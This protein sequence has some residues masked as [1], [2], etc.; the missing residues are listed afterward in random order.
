V[1]TSGPWVEVHGPI[2]TRAI[3][4][5]RLKFTDICRKA[6]DCSRIVHVRLQEILRALC[7]E[8]RVD[9]IALEM[10]PEHVHLDAGWASFLA[11][12]DYKAESA[13]RRVL[14]VNPAGTTQ[15]CSACSTYVPKT[16]TQRWHD[17]PACGLSLSRDEN[18]AREI[19]RLGLSRAE[20]T[21]PAGACVSA[22]APV[23]RHGE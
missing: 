10:M 5:R 9:M 22:E 4:Y 1:R 19:L 2:T 14:R 23:F 12:L 3:C 11:K 7:K 17:C 8:M 20:Q 15:R 16:L 18:A 6:P 13:G 21:W